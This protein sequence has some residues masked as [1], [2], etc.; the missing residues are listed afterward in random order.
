MIPQP[1]KVNRTLNTSLVDSIPT[2][3]NGPRFGVLAGYDI[4]ADDVAVDTN[5]STGAASATFLVGSPDPL[6]IDEVGS[7]SNSPSQEVQFSEWHDW[8]SPMSAFSAVSNSLSGDN[9]AAVAA[10]PDPPLLSGQAGMGTSLLPSYQGQAYGDGDQTATTTNPASVTDTGNSGDAAVVAVASSPN[11]SSTLNTAGNTTAVG[12]GGATPAQV[13]QALDASNLGVT[14]AGITVGVLSDSFNNLGGAAADEADG[15][16]PSASHVNV[17]L[18]YASGGSDEGRAMMQIVHDVA[19]DANLDFYT[20]DDGESGP[21]SFAAGILALANA[22]CKVICDDVTYLDEPFFQ[23]DAVADAIATV[24]AEGV[25]FLTCAGNQEAAAFQSTWTPLASATY[26]GTTLTDTLNFGGGSPVQTV[27]IGDGVY[28]NP[29]PFLLQW[30]Q[31]YGAATTDLGVL[32]F[33]DGSLVGEFSNADIDGFTQSNFGYGASYPLIAVDLSPGTYQIAIENLSGPDPTL[34][35]DAL[36]NDSDPSSVSVS[37]AN[38]GTVFGHHMSPY[39]ITVGAVSTADTP[40]FGVTPAESEG[41]SSS[42]A[43]N[44]ALVQLRWRAGSRGA[45]GSRPGGGIGGRR[46]PDVVCQRRA[47]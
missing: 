26:D 22:G 17:L 37:G 21:D 30:N 7:G 41:F 35:K 28:P 6:A 47:Q 5:M 12:S 11:P 45:G 33:S 34:V 3:N 1:E 2:S 36:Y 31:P 4:P 8:P 10:D 43:G 23:N 46:Y 9:A 40:A 15:A 32:F 14:G 42:G 13:R 25:I 44:R 29:V 38:A 39:A 18:D 24:E 16:L 27:T 20:A 19:P